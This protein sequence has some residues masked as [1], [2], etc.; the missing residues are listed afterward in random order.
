MWQGWVTRPLIAKW[1]L[2]GS[3][4]PVLERWRE[5]GSRGTSPGSC[6]TLT[7]VGGLPRAC[8]KPRTCTLISA[9]IFESTGGVFPLHDVCGGAALLPGDE[10]QQ[11]VQWDIGGL[12]VPR[13]E[14]M[15]GRPRGPRRWRFS[16][17][18]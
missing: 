17:A 12:R 2:Q 18:G 3:L 14:E 11:C 1:C 4:A 15:T 7:T 5:K 8:V 9:H 13:V 10:A 6:S 16:E